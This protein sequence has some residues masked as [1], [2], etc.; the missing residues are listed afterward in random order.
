MVREE[1]VMET[2]IAVLVLLDKPNL[3]ATKPPDKNEVL[4]LL[5]CFDMDTCTYICIYAHAYID[6]DMDCTCVLK[7]M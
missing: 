4:Q 6:V 7:E 2:E 1:K 5:S 3:L